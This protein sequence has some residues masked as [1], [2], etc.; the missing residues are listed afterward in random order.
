MLLAIVTQQSFTGMYNLGIVGGS[1]VRGERIDHSAF[2]R[3][4]GLLTIVIWI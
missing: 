4:K 2:L 1:Q 3:P